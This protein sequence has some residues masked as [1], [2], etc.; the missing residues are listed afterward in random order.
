MLDKR[1]AQFLHII[2]GICADGSYK[3]IEK[4]ELLKAMK[5]H[6]SEYSALDQM[7]RYLQDNEMIDI[8]YTD[9]TVYC[10]SVLPKGRVASESVRHK[11]L[12]KHDVTNKTLLYLVAA[13]FGASMVG[14]FIGA[15]IGGW[16]A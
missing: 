9:E 10:V 11:N 6:S 13:S 3:L 5:I 1:T 16:L 14:A 2:A 4:A 8:K 12:N 15:L 7:L